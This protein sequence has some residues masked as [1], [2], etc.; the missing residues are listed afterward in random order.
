MARFSL[1]IVRDVLNA[2]GEPSFGNGALEVLKG[3]P[4]LGWEYTKESLK[5]ITPDV[6]ARYDALYV[7]SSRVSA[8]T[9]A[10]GDCRLRIIARH[11][12]GYDSVDVPALSAKRIVLTNTPLAVRRPVAVA[13]LTLLFA[14]AGRLFAKD[15]ITRAGRWTDKND[16][17]GMGLVGRTLGVVGGGGIGQEL[18]RVSAPFGMRRV[19]ADPYASDEAMRALDASRVPLEQLLRESD[20]V[21]ITCLLNEETHHLI[22]APQFAL[23]KPGAY[24]INVARGPIV[25]ELALIEALRAGRIAG[26]GLDVFEQEPVDSANPLLGMD[27]VIVTPHGLCWTDECFHAIAS[28]GLQG[29]V[30]FSLGRR[31][32]HIVNPEAWG[33]A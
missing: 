19:V 14:L 10:S 6:A 33:R 3:N 4:E 21:V 22:G 17:M 30:D 15:R 18:L 28:S 16:L 32:A 1:G 8:A 29:V 25:D 13:T 9:V 20:F 24:F 11:G 26:A 7:N 12:V 5:E 2:S 27:N 31:P 23:M